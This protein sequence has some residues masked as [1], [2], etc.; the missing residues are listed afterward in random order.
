MA[1]HHIH[2]G[3]TRQNFRHSEPVVSNNNVHHDNVAAVHFLRVLAPAMEL[4]LVLY[5][6]CN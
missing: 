4:C 1:P 5:G 3:G 6:H 2:S